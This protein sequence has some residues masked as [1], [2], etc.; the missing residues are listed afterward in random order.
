MTPVIQLQ[1][2][3]CLTHT[4]QRRCLPQTGRS[5]PGPTL[6]YGATMGVAVGGV[7]FS[8]AVQTLGEQL[9]RRGTQTERENSR[10]QWKAD[11]IAADCLYE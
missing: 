9:G 1:Q 3:L 5:P 6:S 2:C 8:S 10:G 4:Q 11:I 7:A